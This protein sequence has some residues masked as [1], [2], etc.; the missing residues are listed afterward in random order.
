MLIQYTV[1]WINRAHIMDLLLSLLLTF[2]SIKLQLLPVWGYLFSFFP[3]VHLN[4][5]LKTLPIVCHQVLIAK[6]LQHCCILHTNKMEKLTLKNSAALSILGEF[7][8]LIYIQ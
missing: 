8:I 4:N 5:G 7:E 3:L 1:D 6:T 2:L